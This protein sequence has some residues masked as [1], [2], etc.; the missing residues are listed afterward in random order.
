MAGGASG[1]V[2]L[3]VA[4]TA[5]RH[6]GVSSSNIPELSCIKK[7]DLPYVGWRGCV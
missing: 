5:R 7:R 6:S 1:G 4:H 3:I 2:L